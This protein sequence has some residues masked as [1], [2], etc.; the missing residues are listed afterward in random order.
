MDAVDAA[1]A[2]VDDAK[3]AVAGVCLDGVCFRLGVK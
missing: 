3:V 2:A 1:E